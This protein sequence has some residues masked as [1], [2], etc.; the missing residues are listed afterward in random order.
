MSPGASSECFDL[1]AAAATSVRQISCAW[2]PNI[3]RSPAPVAA[4]RRLLPA[5]AMSVPGPVLAAQSGLPRGSN[6]RNSPEL[7]ATTAAEPSLSTA[8]PAIPGISTRV[9]RSPAASMSKFLNAKA[10]NSPP[11]DIRTPTPSVGPIRPP[12]A[13]AGEAICTSTSGLPAASSR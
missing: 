3:T 2:G 9:S 4:N 13:T 6:A 5:V 12:P 7:V 10:A 11:G 1:S 8:M